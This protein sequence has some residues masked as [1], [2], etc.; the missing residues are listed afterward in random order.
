MIEGARLSPTRKSQRFAPKQP[1]TV[2]ISKDGAS[3]AYGIVSNISEGG[4]C[5]QTH[6]VPRHDLL[7]LVLSFYDGEYLQATGRVVWS[8]SQEGLATVGVEF[9]GLDEQARRCLRSNF[10]SGSFSPV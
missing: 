4:A 5:F 2:A 8:D 10:G 1:V 6:A 9:T 7:E 3:F